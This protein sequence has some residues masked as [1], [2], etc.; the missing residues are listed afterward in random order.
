MVSTVNGV[1]LAGLLLSTGEALAMEGGST[2]GV[3]QPIQTIASPAT[4]SGESALAFGGHS[5]YGLLY[6]GKLDP[7][8]G[9]GG[10]WMRLQTPIAEKQTSFRLGFQSTLLGWQSTVSAELPLLTHRQGRFFATLGPELTLGT[11]LAR[12]ALLPVFA[13]G[14]SGRVGM[15]VL[16]KWGLELSVSPSVTF[17][18]GYAPL[19]ELGYVGIDM[20]ILLGLRRNLG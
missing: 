11:V 7:G 15:H 9:G 10:I 4:P 16:G 8:N 1:L 13:L 3:S 12:P 6:A 17:C 20:P 5:I 18:P 14:G 19:G 2:E